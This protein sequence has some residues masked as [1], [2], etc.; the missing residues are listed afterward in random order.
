MPP[1][2]NENGTVSYY[3]EG[4]IQVKQYEPI[5]V[6][7]GLTLPLDVAEGL[8]RNPAD[9][10]R[11]DAALENLADRV[12]PAFER[13]MVARTAGGEFYRDPNEVRRIMNLPPPAPATAPRRRTS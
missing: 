2:Q 6:M 8:N 13:A 1:A 11:V 12:T 10:A 4:T 3:L 9:K 7:V 5:K